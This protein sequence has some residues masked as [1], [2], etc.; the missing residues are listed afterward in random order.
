[1]S[2]LRL[3][4][5]AARDLLADAAGS[6]AHSAG[7]DGA[8]HGKPFC[9][10]VGNLCKKRERGEFGSDIG[11][12]RGPCR[13]RAST[14]KK[15]LGSSSAISTALAAREPTNSKRNLAEEGSKRDGSV[16]L[17]EKVDPQCAQ[18][19]KRSPIVAACAR[20][21]SIWI[22]AVRRFPSA[23]DRPRFRERRSRLFRS[24][25]LDFGLRRFVTKISDEFHPPNQ[26]LHRL[27]LPK[28]RS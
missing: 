10:Q 13:P 8:T 26:L 19:R 9:K 22:A 4:R 21:I 16:S 23:S 3:P 7:V 6:I 12:T 2:D 18:H 14:P 5:E 27:A 28:R 20:T 11:R 1:M 15:L 24:G 25:H 17:L